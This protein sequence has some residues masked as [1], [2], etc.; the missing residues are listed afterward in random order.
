MGGERV[1]EV[2]AE[3]RAPDRA[4]AAR[5]RTAR[6]SAARPPAGA[7]ARS[8]IRSRSLREPRSRRATRRRARANSG[9]PGSVPPS[10]IQSS[11]YDSGSSALPLDH[12]GVQ[13]DRR[14][15]DPRPRTRSRP[16]APSRLS[17][18]P[19]SCATPPGARCSPTPVTNAATRSSPTMPPSRYSYAGTPG[20]PRGDDERRIRDD[21]VEL[22]ARDRV[23]QAPEPGLDAARRPLSSALSRVKPQRALRDVGRDDV[24]RR[25]G[26][27]AA[28]GCRIRCRCRVRV[29][30]ASA[31]AAPARVSDA[32]PTPEHVILG[33]RPA[34]GGLVEVARDPPLPRA[35]GRRRTTAG[36][37]WRAA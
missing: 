27:R 8:R 25:R 17:Q 35:A 18:L 24:G 3:R 30:R 20:D 36:G 31:A 37:R 29:D 5:A 10:R 4:P 28:P 7:A 34:Q 1:G 12:P 19:S 16:A 23:E 33:E 21:A 9:M 15:I 6:G 26:A 2:R 32:P 13:R 22:L 14:R 11:A